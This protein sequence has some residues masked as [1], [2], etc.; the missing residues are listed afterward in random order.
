MSTA[1]DFL[2]DEQDRVGS[3]TLCPPLSTTKESGKCFREP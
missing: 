1:A 3:K 2:G